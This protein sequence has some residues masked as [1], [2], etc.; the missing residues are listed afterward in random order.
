MQKTS[1]DDAE[2]Q[3]VLD[4]LR[5]LVKALG[6]SSRSAQARVG[7]TGAQLFVLQSLRGRQAISMNQLAERTR[8]HQSTVSVVVKRLV[9]A[10]L[11]ARSVAADDGRRLALS[12]TAAGRARLK[13]APQAAQEGLIAGL[14]R[15][16][17][18]TRACLARDLHRLVEAMRLDDQPPAMFFEE[19]SRP[20]R[21]PTHG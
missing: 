19:G 20:R 5:R 6:A 2:L 13:K 4:D 18:P 17:R 11:V 14:E 16:P 12:L 15:L 10:G 3:S 9:A 21:R 7:L 1:L 8:T